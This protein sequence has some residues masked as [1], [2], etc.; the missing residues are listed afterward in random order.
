VRLGPRLGDLRRQGVPQRRHDAGRLG[1]DRMHRLPVRAGGVRRA[2]TGDR[3]ALGHDAGGEGIEAM[4]YIE[5]QDVSLTY[6]TPSRRV[7]GVVDVSFGID[8]S[9]FLCIV[10][11]SGCGKSTL[12]NMIAGFLKPTS[13]EI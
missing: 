2:G 13:G 11:P 9:E 1:G 8:A 4:P 3:P 12:L 10:G 6:D 5:V 7:P